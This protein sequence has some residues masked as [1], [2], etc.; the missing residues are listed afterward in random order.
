MKISLFLLYSLARICMIALLKREDFHLKKKLLASAVLATSLLVTTNHSNV[1]QAKDNQEIATSELNQKEVNTEKKTY[2]EQP[3]AGYVEYNGKQIAVKEETKEVAEAQE[4][5]ITDANQSAMGANIP[6]LRTSTDVFYLGDS[7]RPRQDFIDISSYQSGLDQSDF[8]YMKSKG[9]TGVVV[10]LTEGTSYR[11]PYACE[12]IRKA[13]NAGMKVSTYHFSHFKNKAQAEAEADYYAQYA[14]ELG[15]G[16]DTLM[17]NDAETGELQNGYGTQN[18]VYFALRLI[19]THGFN[20]VLHYMSGSWVNNI[21]DASTLGET[22]LWIAGYPYSPSKDHMWYTN[23]EAWQFSSTMKIN[24][25]SGYLDVNTDYTGRFTYGKAEPNETKLSNTYFKVWN[26]NGYT[27]NDRF[28]TSRKQSTKSMKDHIYEARGYIEVNGAKW[29]SLFDNNGN[30]MGWTHEYD[31]QPVSQPEEHKL[32]YF[33]CATVW[34]GNGTTYRDRLIQTPYQKTSSMKNKTYEVRGYIEVNG[35]RWFSLF[36]GNGNWMGWTHE[37]DLKLST[38]TETPVH[39][40]CQVWNGNGMT[41][42]DRMLTSGRYKTANMKNKTYEARGYIEVNGA[43]WYSLFDSNGNW[44]GWTHEYDL[45]M[46]PTENAVADQTYATVWNGNGS[47]RN[48]RFVTSVR[49]KTNTMKNKTY[50]VRGYIVVDGAKWY[51]LFDA[52]GHWMGW[53]HEYDLH[54]SNRTETPLTNTYFKVWNGNGYTYNDRMLANKKNATANMKDQVYEA[55]G[56]IVVDGAKWY[57]LF[58]RSGHWMGWTHEYDLEATTRDRMLK[59]NTSSSALPTSAPMTSTMANDQLNMQAKE[60]KQETTSTSA[61]NA[62]M[63][64]KEVEVVQ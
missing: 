4:V 50:E 37:Y 64:V 5:K 21:L 8:N 28:I 63:Q 61:M 30:W 23:R 35:A 49:Y 54:L 16:K 59:E 62:Q 60:V 26:G 40:T 24:G 43:K 11:N 20:A 53:T 17:V 14:N 29:Y 56:Y 19:R 6:K 44:K 46:E 51:S 1:V 57:S 48:D 31:L 33:T 36:D 3:T 18:S 10:K 25:Y 27:Y 15:L 12:Q 32:E 34:N 9:I 2:E 38:R 55:R 47:T 45:R 58:D 7:S 13:R 22:S 39:F 52:S 41:Y 42:N